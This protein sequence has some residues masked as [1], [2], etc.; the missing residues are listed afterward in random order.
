MFGI[1]FIGSGSKGNCALLEL[2]G[3]YYLLDAGLSCKKIKDFLHER[4]LGVDDLSGIFITHEHEDHIKG[5][6]V[7]L[8]KASDLPVYCTQ[9]TANA[10][11]DRNI[12]IKNHV[13]LTLKK[14]IKLGDCE[15]VPFR[16][17]HDAADPSGFRFSTSQEV[18]S[19]ATDL[20]H[21]TNEV[22]E[23]VQ[24][25]D[26]VCL[27]SNYDDD[28]L[29]TCLYPTWLKSRIRGPMGHLPNEGVRGLLSRMKKVPEAIILMHVSQESNK[30]ELALGALKPFFENSGAIFKS[31]KLCVVAQDKPSERFTVERQLPKDMKQRFLFPQIKDI[32]RKKVS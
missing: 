28:M 4:Q 19:L 22:I 11:A 10:I 14:T 26:I 15:C 30:P 2:S 32:L 27:E 16:V 6:R 25:A 9:G 13:E 31:A 1:T 5:L 29:R 21:V 23:H 12:E 7:L 17:P 18:M 3:E 8:G 24:D 20:G